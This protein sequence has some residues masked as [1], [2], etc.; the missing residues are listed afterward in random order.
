MQD[1]ILFKSSSEVVKCQ[2]TST[3][4]SR[5]SGLIKRFDDQELLKSWKLPYDLFSKFSL[6]SQLSYELCLYLPAKTLTTVP[7]KPPSKRFPPTSHSLHNPITFSRS[8]LH[9]TPW[10]LQNELPQ[11]CLYHSSPF[12][13]NIC[14]SPSPSS[15]LLFFFPLPMSPPPPFVDSSTP[16]SHKCSNAQ[17]TP[18]S[19]PLYYLDLNAISPRSA[20]EIASLFTSTAPSVRLIDGGI[21]GGA[22]SP[23]SNTDSTPKTT[24]SS[25]PDTAHEWKRPSIPVCGPHQLTSPDAPKSGTNFAE[26]LNLNHISDDIGVA[27]GLKCCFASTTKGFTALCIQAFTTASNLGVLDLLKQEMG[28]RIPGMLKSGTGGVTASMH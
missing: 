21:I 1:Y 25:H 3:W 9:V 19:T 27:S 14:P 17:P 13:F 26:V 22:P 12:Y 24:V 7:S 18:K 16:Y 28:D 4:R 11:H 6:S 20:R 10:Q 2:F 5:G 15:T 8:S 23:K